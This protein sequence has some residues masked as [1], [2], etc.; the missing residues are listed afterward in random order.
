MDFRK[1][2]P[3]SRLLAASLRQQAG[4]T[5]LE[6]LVA[7]GIGAVMGLALMQISS[8]EMHFRSDTDARAET[9]QG[10]TAA[11]DALTRDVRL[12]GS[13]LP[14]QPFFV[15]I[16][17]NNNGTTDTITLRTGVISQTT[18]CV[19]ADLTSALTAGATTLQVDNLAG[20]TVD[21]LGYIVSNVPGEFFHVTAVSGTSGAGTITT[22]TSL[23]QNYPIGAGAYALEERTYNIDSTNYSIPTLVL[24]TNRHA[25]FPIAMGIETLDVQYRLTQNCPTCTVVDLP[26]D[27]PT[28][29]QVSEVILNM[30]ARSLQR[31]SVG[32]LFRESSTIAIQPRNLVTLRSG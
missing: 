26:P 12:A 30:T 31:L 6:L 21:G 20:F 28:W 13:C 9:H 24:S 2:K 15:P 5:M 25:A 19:Q 7:L 32:G 11:F 10:L 1:P 17:G 27:D 8:T 18:T 23:A 16:A 29:V 22:D 14:T 4:F 3:M